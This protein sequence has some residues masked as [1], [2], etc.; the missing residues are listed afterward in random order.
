MPETAATPWLEIIATPPMGRAATAQ[1]A[2]E[3]TTWRAVVDARQCADDQ[4]FFEVMKGAL[5]LPAYFGFN[6]D[7]FNECFLDLLDI[8]EGGMGSAFGGREG[9]PADQLYLVISHAEHLLEHEGASRLGILVR[10]LRGATRAAAT[11]G[12]AQATLN[13]AMCCTDST[14]DHFMERMR[15]AGVGPDDLMSS[16]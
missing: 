10:I 15:V 13:V 6:W 5:D 12:R 7:A 14:F 8:S 4:G 11:Y 16:G 9:K 2:T 3:P 1:G